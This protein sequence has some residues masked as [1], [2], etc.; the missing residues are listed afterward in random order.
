VPVEIVEPRRIL[1]EDRVFDGPVGWT[2]RLE[3]VTLLHLFRDFETAQPFDLPLRRTG[4]YRVSAPQHMVLL[5]GA[6]GKLAASPPTM[7][8]EN[9]EIRT[10]R[11]SFQVTCGSIFPSI[12]MRG[13]QSAQAQGWLGAPCLLAGY[14]LTGD[15]AMPLWGRADVRD[16]RS[17]ALK[18]RIFIQR[19]PAVGSPF[20]G[21]IVHH[22]P[23]EG[24]RAPR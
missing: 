10:D 7:A 24:A 3:A 1:G 20:R 15:G 5:L 21:N 18:N 6:N 8:S 14:V 9:L 16:P 4:P 13:K 17:A 2:Q 11:E 22:C 19:N 23:T 12:K